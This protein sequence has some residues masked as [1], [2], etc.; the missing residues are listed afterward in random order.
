MRIHTAAVSVGVSA[1]LTRPARLHLSG[2]IS[3]PAAPP[4]FVLASKGFR[5]FFLLAALFAVAILP[6]WMLNL[7]GVLRLD[8]YLDPMSWHAHEMVFGFAT[9]VIAG[10]LLTAVGNWA[11]RETAI[12]TPLLLLSALWLLGRVAMAAAFALPK[13]LPA[14]IDLAFI[15][16]LA[17]AIGR[18]LVIARNR[19]NFSMLG[20]LGA[21]WLANL[22]VH[23]DALGVLPGWRLRASIVGVDVVI[24]VI[25]MI[26]GRVFPMF[27][28]NATGVASIRSLPVLD[29][30][31]VGALALL[32]VF[33]ALAPGATK[34]A[35]VVA[36]IAAVLAIA[37][38]VH[39]GAR[40]SFRQPL[41]WILH[42]GYLWIPLALALRAIATF[43]PAL[44]STLAIHA[45]TVGTIGALTLGMMSRVTL[46][47][48]GRTLSAS[49]PVLASFVLVTL[50]A[51]V[52]VFVPL[53]GAVYYRPSLFIAGTLWTAAFGLYLA[54]YASLLVAPRVD[55]K[56]G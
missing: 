51:A 25:A 15:P 2:E 17:F 35:A 3:S 10:F 39:W 12:G 9:A 11:Q 5:P 1:M 38:S 52:R 44:S 40:H 50:A 31:A 56:P 21:L 54:V 23:L 13:W 16:A 14:V 49:R 42:V 24:V 47:H 28:R 6:V 53:F 19:R 37:R 8:G 4:S 32:A 34:I 20:V 33:D 27:T 30:M 7:L 36:G 55:G 46:G 18:P 43:V 48:T 41:L 22:C 29:R 45:L 26:A